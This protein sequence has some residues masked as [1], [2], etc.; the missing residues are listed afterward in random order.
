M[1]GGFGQSLPL[2]SN[3]NA[4]HSL[5]K[6]DDTNH[7][8]KEFTSIISIALCPE[9][10]GCFNAS[11]YC[12]GTACSAEMHRQTPPWYVVCSHCLMSAPWEGIYRCSGKTSFPHQPGSK[13]TCSAR[14]Q[15]ATISLHPSYCRATNPFCKKKLLSNPSSQ[16]ST[17]TSC[18]TALW[19]KREAS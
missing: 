6:E 2:N 10:A 7:L 14:E 4:Q 1:Q 8:P 13:Q 15:E 19:I 17:F 16:D 5:W 9:A 18:P 3:E 11:C 12:L